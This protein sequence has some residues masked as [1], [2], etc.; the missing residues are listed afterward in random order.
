MRNVVVYA[1][2]NYDWLRIDKALGIFTN[3]IT[4]RWT[5][6]L[7]FGDPSGSKNNSYYTVFRKKK[8]WVGVFFWTQCKFRVCEHSL[9]F[10]FHTVKG[11]GH[12][13]GLTV[14]SSDKR[15]SINNG[16]IVITRSS[17]RGCPKELPHA[18][19]LWSVKRSEV[20][21]TRSFISYSIL[22]LVPRH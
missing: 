18:E 15:C 4:T 2:S 22:R 21:V 6:F 16:R 20:K 1:K 12:A 10:W 11:Q 14:R 7:A 19:T 17:N 8:T 9:S 3:L 13:P 5:T